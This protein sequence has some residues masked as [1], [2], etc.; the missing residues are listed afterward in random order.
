MG[1][2]IIVRKATAEKARSKKQPEPK[3]AKKSKKRKLSVVVHQ[4]EARGEED[5]SAFDVSDDEEPAQS[6]VSRGQPPAKKRRMWNDV[7]EEPE[8]GKKGKELETSKPSALFKPREGRK[9]TLSMAVPGSIIANV[10]KPDHKTLLAGRIARAAAVFC[11]DE[12][13]VFDDDPSTIPDYVDRRYRQKNKTKQEILDGI[14]ENDQPWQDPDQFLFHVLSYAECPPYLRR[15][16]QDRN[17]GLF[18]EH[19]NLRWVGNLPSLDMPHHL[20]DYEWCQYREGVT[21]GPAQSSK[22]KDKK[23]RS[24]KEQAQKEWTYVKCGLPYPVKIPMHIPRYTRTTLKFA[25]TNPPPSWPNLSQGQCEALEVN[26][27][28]PDTPREEKGYYWGY[29]VRRATSISDVMQDCDYEDGYDLC[30]GTSER[31]ATLN[32]ILPDAIAPRNRTKENSIENLPDT[33]EHLL[34]VFGGVAG[35]EPAV[36]SDPELKATGLTKETAHEV[37]DAWVNLVQGQGSRTI[38]TEEAIE[39][40]LFGLKGYVDSMYT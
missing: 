31:G 18:K 15:D 38:R 36:A 16:A 22:P 9:W 17:A 12:I 30:I 29:Q 8:V 21:L 26:A 5:I 25:T 24:S 10:A 40:G 35:L 11:V 23:T 14:D 33:F 7:V 1:D 3:K 28:A 13:I 39:F 4:N 20:K 2:A 27:V 19:Q 34:I 6:P 37:F 32:S